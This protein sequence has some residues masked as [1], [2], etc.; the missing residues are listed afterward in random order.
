[1][2][3]IGKQILSV[4]FEN[5]GVSIHFSTFAVVMASSELPLP[6]KPNSVPLRGEQP[7]FH[8]MRPTSLVDSL[9][10]VSDS[11]SP[12]GLWTLN[13]LERSTRVR[14]GILGTSFVLSSVQWGNLLCHRDKEALLYQIFHHLPNSIENYPAALSLQCP[15]LKWLLAPLCPQCHA[16]KQTG[17]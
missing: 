15:G 8:T 13:L 16:Q 5:K 2:W 6:V 11:D 4:L 7:C 1:M 10:S 17:P 3:G 14:S 12:R 9:G